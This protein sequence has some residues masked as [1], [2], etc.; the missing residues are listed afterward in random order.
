MALVTKSEL[1][2]AAR[3]SLRATAS[4]SAGE[5]LRSESKQRSYARKYNIFLSHR[6]L[7]AE[8]VLGLVRLIESCGLSVY[9]DWR[10]D[11]ELDRTNV[12][13]LNAQV[14]RNQMGLCDALFF[15]T[16]TNFTDSKWMPWELGYFDGKKGRVAIVPVVEDSDKFRNF[17]GQEYLGIY[18]YVEINKL[19]S[20]AE[21]IVFIH[22]PDGPQ[23]H[24]YGRWIRTGS[25][26]D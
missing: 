16:T 24:T 12:T 10:E 18:P 26:P 3:T 7:D 14:L 11:P 21:P 9:I 1:R 17:H 5:E 25:L 6:K 19:S 13:S 20:Y 22:A 8:E 2:T 15:A 4:I 23:F